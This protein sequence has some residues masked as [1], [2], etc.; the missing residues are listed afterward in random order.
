MENQHTGVHKILHQLKHYLP[1]QTPLKDFIH[2]NSLHAF[3]DL[4]FYDAIFRASKIFGYQATLPLTDFR[5]L[6]EIGR[7]ND[8]I[9]YRVI[10]K[11]YGIENMALW[12][13]KVISGSYDEHNEQRIG[14]LRCHWKKKCQLD[15]D[16]L[17]QPILFRLLS[18]YLDQGIA[19]FSFPV[20]NTG[21]L[22]ALRI[23]EKNS[24]TSLF[25]TQRARE[26]FLREDISIDVLLQIVVGDES[27]FEQYLFDQQFSHR[28]WSGMVATIEEHPASLF[29][30]KEISLHDLVLFELLLEI[31]NLEEALG[32]DWLPLSECIKQE[33]MEIFAEVP[34]T[35][36]QEVLRIWQ[37]AFEWSYYDEI[38]AGIIQLNE[39]K[40]RNP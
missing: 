18:N 24:F 4:K 8:G 32:K 7:I 31:D 13:E 36:L 20:G 23:L 37:D 15:L 35:E 16:N 9:L 34:K 17:V 21:F 1:S 19:I 27:Y 10:E 2:H 14:K 25:K 39:H 33:P 40:K 29:S 6:Y 30:R 3:Q 5:K 22:N 38:L 26:L 12:K 11:R 28:G